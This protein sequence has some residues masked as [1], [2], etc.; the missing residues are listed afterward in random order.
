MVNLLWNIVTAL[1]TTSTTSAHAQLPSIIVYGSQVG[2]LAG[3]LLVRRH[4]KYV[5]FTKLTKF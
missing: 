5:W 2:M 3:I 4:L 1:L